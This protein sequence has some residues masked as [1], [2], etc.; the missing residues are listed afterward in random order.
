MGA[1]VLVVD[2]DHIAGGLSRDLLI[3]GG[4]DATLLTESLKA[5][6][7]IKRERPPLV[8]L[9]ILMPGV[10]GLTLCHQ[11]SSEPTL[12]DIKVIIISGKSFQSDKD[13]ARKYGA[14][15][16]IEKPYN[17]EGFLGQIQEVMG[18]TAP[19]GEG[20]FWSEI[21]ARSSGRHTF[22]TSACPAA[23][24]LS[25]S[26]GAWLWPTCWMHRCRKIC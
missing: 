4:Y 23:T 3:E 20:S 15:L 18:R 17:V 19:S 12:K 2:D 21:I 26:R 11:I 25:E 1:K 13:R 10:D 16:F 6:D 24:R 9:D 5:M 8:I 14:I 22:A 7:W